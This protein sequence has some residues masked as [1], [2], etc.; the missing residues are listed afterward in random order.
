MILS[1]TIFRKNYQINSLYALICILLLSAFLRVYKIDFQSFWHDELHSVI[2]SDPQ[3]TFLQVIEYC[4][5]DSPPLHF[6]MLHYW[7]KVFGD[8]ERSARL[9]SSLIGIAGVLMMFFLGEEFKNQK[10]GL[11]SSFITSIN[12]FHIFYS[13]EARFYALVFL[14][15]GLSF[16]FFLRSVR[17]ERIVDFGWYIVFT[18]A[19]VYTHYFGLVVFLAQ[20]LLFLIIVAFAKRDKIFIGKAVASGALILI[21]ISPYV[22]TFIRDNATTSMWIPPLLLSLPFRFFFQ[23]F[24]DF[25]SIL[26]F[27]C[28]I[29]Y[30]LFT[31]GAQFYKTGRIEIKWVIVMG[32]ILL[33]FLIPIVYSLIKF[34]LLISRYTMITLPGI[35]LLIATG[36]E[37]LH[38]PKIQ[39]WLSIVV[40]FSS[41]ITLIYVSEYYSRLRNEQFREISELILR[42]RKSNS[43]IYSTDA[44]YFNYYFR[45]AD[46][47]DEVVLPLDHRLTEDLQKY[48]SIWIASLGP[49]PEQLLKALDASHFLLKHDYEFHRGN[50][51]LFEKNKQ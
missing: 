31:L 9:L 17:L 13:Q 44:W 26:I 25:V 7:L 15:S 2:E 11:I 36:F 51:M 23:Y 47:K 30:S 45:L 8:N 4:K 22:P 27:G 29:V 24:R 40:L 46:G 42:N 49:V 5:S 38:T 20:G 37:L 41:L 43:L 12:Y 18:S 35:L 3:L 32:W 14:L 34:P 48:E 21:I 33:T 16:L 19:I 10:V 50:A 39:R 1:F 28:L 6:V